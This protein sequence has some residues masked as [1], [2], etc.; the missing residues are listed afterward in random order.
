MLA[1]AGAVQGPGYQGSGCH[2]GSFWGVLSM[3]CGS[4]HCDMCHE[5]DF[6]SAT[7]GAG[8]QGSYKFILTS[9][10]GFSST[11]GTEGGFG[12]L[13]INI[14]PRGARGNTGK[15]RRFGGAG[16]GMDG[17]CIFKSF[18]EQGC[19]IPILGAGDT[20]SPWEQGLERLAMERGKE[21]PVGPLR[22]P[23]NGD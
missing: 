13:E 14:R 20:E 4:C 21:S 10:K 7:Q 12:K 1:W 19:L 5:H 2:A 3:W 16:A 8:S 22:R 18:T 23:Q 9:S 11:P 15:H 6:S 17:A